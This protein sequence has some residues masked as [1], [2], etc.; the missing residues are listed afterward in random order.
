LNLIFGGRGLP[1]NEIIDDLV[2]SRRSVSPKNRF[3]PTNLFRF[4]PKHQAD[5]VTCGV[6]SCSAGTHRRGN[7]GQPIVYKA[8]QQADR[9]EIAPITVVRH[10]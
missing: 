3:D 5:R 7:A 4:N 8:F 9:K 10:S 1:R 6:N 2:S